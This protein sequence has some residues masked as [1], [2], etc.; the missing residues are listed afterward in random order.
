MRLGK[1]EENDYPSSSRLHEIKLIKEPIFVVLQIEK[2]I[3][4]ER[5]SDQLEEMS[6]DLIA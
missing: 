6:F 2:P 5:T 4:G 1:D 3:S